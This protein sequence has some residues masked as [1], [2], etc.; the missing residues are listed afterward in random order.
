MNLSAVDEQAFGAL[1]EP[2]RRELHVHCY[3]IMG[4]GQ[5]AEDMVQETFLRA[6]RRRETF[7]GRASLRAWLYK[8]A[9]NNCLDALEKRARRVV[10]FTRQA[11]STLDQPI[12]PEVNEAIWLEPFPDELLPADDAQ[13]DQ[14]YAARED[15]TLAF[16][17]VLHLLP[18][19]QRAVLILRDVLEWEASEVA[20]LLG[21]TVASV[22]SALHRARTTMAAHKR[23]NLEGVAP[24]QLDADRQSQLADYVAAWQ[25]ADVNGLMA[26]LR[27]DATFSMPPIPSWY[28]GRA[29]IGGLVGKTIFAGD[30]AGRWRLLPTRAN[31]QVAFC[32]YRL[33]AAQGIYT[34]YGVQVL[35][36]G[37]GQIADIITFRNPALVAYFKLPPTVAI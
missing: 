36:F 2:F 31:G 10:P 7:E 33:D 19:R 21:V 35:T 25:N 18:P 5:D 27:E 8:I 28:Q 24:Q 13:P 3:R 20:D 29:T 32:L 4:S 6:W 12:P 22:K 26:L 34:G 23:A 1:A 15:I 16:I 9:T 30:A 14:Y 11:A 37:E 17:T